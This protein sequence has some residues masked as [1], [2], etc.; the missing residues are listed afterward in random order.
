MSLK[1]LALMHGASS[2]HSEVMV[3]AI[4]PHRTG[5]KFSPKLIVFNWGCNIYDGDVFKSYD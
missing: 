2:P 3:G 4:P 1:S 5:S